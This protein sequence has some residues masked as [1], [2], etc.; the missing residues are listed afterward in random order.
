MFVYAL[1]FVGTRYSMLHG[2]TSLDL[3]ALRYSVSGDALLFLTGVSWGLFTL[4]ARVWNVRPLQAAA[5]VSVLS[6]VYLPVYLVFFY[7]GFAGVSMLHIA[8]QAAFQ[9]L[10]MSLAALSLLTFA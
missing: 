6:M 3:A 2:L 5:I 10:G 7:R 1:N 9:G 8:S 4:F